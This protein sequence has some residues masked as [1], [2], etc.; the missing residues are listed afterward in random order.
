MI[1]SVYSDWRGP[2]WEER[3]PE[4]WK[5]GEHLTSEGSK[6]QQDYKIVAMTHIRIMKEKDNVISG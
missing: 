2:S 1:I 5:S 4:G 3:N 6:Y